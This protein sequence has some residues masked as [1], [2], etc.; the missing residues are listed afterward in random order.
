MEK[1]PISQ[2][3]AMYYAAVKID[4]DGAEKMNTEIPLIVATEEGGKNG[5]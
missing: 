4:W 3:K 2:F 1:L 5:D